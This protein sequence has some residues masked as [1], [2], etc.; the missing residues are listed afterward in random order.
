MRRVEV[1]D[2]KHLRGVL[3]LVRLEG[4]DENVGDLSIGVNILEFNFTTQDQVVHKM[5]MHFYVLRAS[6]EVRILG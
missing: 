1:L 2:T 6:M 4:L 5:V 3:Q